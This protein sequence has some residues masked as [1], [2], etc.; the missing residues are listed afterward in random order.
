[1]YTKTFRRK[2]AG[3]GARKSVLDRGSEGLGSDRQIVA[4]ST[5][6]SM[7]SASAVTCTRREVL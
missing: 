5:N 4:I 1:M 2:L 3:V 7:A 6:V